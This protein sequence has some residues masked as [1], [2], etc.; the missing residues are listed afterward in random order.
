[1]LE[2]HHLRTLTFV[3]ATNARIE[4]MK[5]ENQHRLACGNGISYGEDAFNAQAGELDR[6]AREF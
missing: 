6:L 4:A 1:M 2:P 3:L 5:A